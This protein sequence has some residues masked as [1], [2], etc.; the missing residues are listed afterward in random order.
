MDEVY[1]KI[2][3]MPLRDNEWDFDGDGFVGNSGIE[4]QQK[5]VIVIKTPQVFSQ[6]S[7]VLIAYY[8]FV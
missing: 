3:L 8:F 5:P 7:V 4:G 6:S 2:K 1:S